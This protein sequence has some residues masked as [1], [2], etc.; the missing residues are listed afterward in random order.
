MNSKTANPVWR[1]SQYPHLTQLTA[2]PWFTGAVQGAFFFSQPVSVEI[3]FRHCTCKTNQGV[4][5]CSGVDCMFWDQQKPGQAPKLRAAKVHGFPRQWACPLSL[6]RFASQLLL[7][8]DFT[9]WAR[10]LSP[11]I[12]SWPLKLEQYCSPP[13]IFL[14]ILVEWLLETIV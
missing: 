10:T 6:A 12:V 7:L 14:Y 4:A 13:P 2:I 3:N 8:L 5:T 11:G 1:L 9:S